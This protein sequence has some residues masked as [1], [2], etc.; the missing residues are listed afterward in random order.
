ML[1]IFVLCLLLIGGFKQGATAARPVS[2]A[3]E[4][5]LYFADRS[6]RKGAPEEAIRT[7]ESILKTAPNT[8]Q[9]YLIIYGPLRYRFKKNAGSLDAFT[10]CFKN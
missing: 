7:C 3:V 5:M 8:V 4:R 1:P 9:A 2:N 10:E 6:E